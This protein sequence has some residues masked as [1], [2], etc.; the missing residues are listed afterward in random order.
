[1][2]LKVI[3]QKRVLSSKNVSIFVL[4]LISIALIYYFMT[5]EAKITLSWYTL[6]VSGIL[7]ILFAGMK[8]FHPNSEVKFPDVKESRNI[9]LIIAFL[10]NLVITVLIMYFPRPVIG[11]NL[12]VL[13][14]GGVLTEAS[15]TLIKLIFQIIVTGIL[16]LGTYYI[17][18]RKEEFLFRDLDLNWKKFLAGFTWTFIIWGVI[19]L[20]KLSVSIIDGKPFLPANESELLFT[21]L[22]FVVFLFFVGIYEEVLFRSYLVNQ[23]FLKIQKWEIDKRIAIAVAVIVSSVIF[24]LFHLPN[25]LTRNDTIPSL[26]L[27]LGLFDLFLAGVIFSLF[28]LSTGNVFLVSGIHGLIDFDNENTV[29]YMV[30]MLVIILFQKN[31]KTSDVLA[32]L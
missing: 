14:H 32:S 1:L 25:Y 12:L 17:L 2:N 8:L 11:R 21:S 27:Y 6:V 19:L 26:I 5:L 28:Y 16:F 4:A 22:D 20:F 31:R 29:L 18:K 10:F 23:L 3:S 9:T 15:V 7:V 30:I 24:S 13:M